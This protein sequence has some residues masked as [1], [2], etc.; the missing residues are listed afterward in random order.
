MMA[1]LHELD[2][3]D[4]TEHRSLEARLVGHC[5]TSSVLAVSFYRQL[6]AAARVRCGF[7][8]YYAD[9]RDFYG[10]HW[11]VELWNEPTQTWRL[12]DTEL[13]EPTRTAHNIS[14]DPANVPRDQLI[15]AG[16]AWIDC[17]AGSADPRMF[18]PYPDRTGWRRVG[19]QLLR[20]VACL[21]GL[22]VGPFDSWLPIELYDSH[23]RALDAL[24]AATTDLDVTGQRLRLLCE[25]NPWVLPP[26]HLADD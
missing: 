26:A 22:E 11:V 20:D 15:L 21:C 17:R 19:D 13:D 5:R 2:R 4:L 14:F 8:V 23:E 9:G 10:D 6:G 25:E 18:G 12:L 24:A 16:K 3:A 1:R 7:S